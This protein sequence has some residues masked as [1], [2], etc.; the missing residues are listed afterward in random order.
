MNERDQTPA[1]ATAPPPVSAG[2]ATEGTAGVLRPAD[3]TLLERTYLGVLDTGMVSSRLAADPS[4]RMDAVTAV[5]LALREDLPR[6]TYLDGDGPEPTAAF[7]AD[8]TAA[9]HAL[10][11]RGVLSAGP[12]PPDIILS[13]EM[14][15]PRPPATLD[16]DQHPRIWDRYLA[17]QCMEALFADPRVYPYLMAKYQDSSDVYARLY[18]ENPQRFL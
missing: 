12:P 14:A 16:F 7:I 6:D 5:C 3:L 4:L 2:S 17:H 9:V 10:D 8:L 13:P 15:R 1:G 11:A 18:T